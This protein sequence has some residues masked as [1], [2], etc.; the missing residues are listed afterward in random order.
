MLLVDA[1]I[2]RSRIVAHNVK[3]SVVI[4]MTQSHSSQLLFRDLGQAAAGTSSGH[5]LKQRS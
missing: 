3:G 4:F 5:E 1:R 2:P